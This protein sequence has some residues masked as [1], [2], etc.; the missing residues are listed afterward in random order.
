MPP[1][2]KRPAKPNTDRADQALSLEYT[3][4]SVPL[5]FE[6]KIDWKANPTE[7]FD[8]EWTWQFGRHHWWPSL[9]R[10]YW[11]TGDEKYVKQFVWE[12]RSWVR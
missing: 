3:I 6:G 7:P 2:D 8:P 5:K 10:A 12:M 11:D 1:A 9:A 4:T